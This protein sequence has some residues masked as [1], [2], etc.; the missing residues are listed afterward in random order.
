[1]N[2]I[3]EIIIKEHW[4][5]NKQGLFKLYHEAEEYLNFKYSLVEKWW[6]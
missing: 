2:L 6:M 3:I 5:L 1:M 4:I